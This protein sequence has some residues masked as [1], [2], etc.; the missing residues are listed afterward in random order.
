MARNMARRMGESGTEV[1][2]VGG[3]AAAVEDGDEEE[4]DGAPLDTGVDVAPSLPDAAARRSSFMM[5][6]CRPVPV[7]VA[8]STP[9]SMANLL[10]PGVARISRAGVDDDDDDEA[11]T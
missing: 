11:G 5:R 3:E 4:V 2:V 9:F 8:R 1:V 10:V 6:P 7:T